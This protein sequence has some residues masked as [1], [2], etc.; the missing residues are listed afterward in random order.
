M[1]PPDRVIPVGDDPLI[2]SPQTL[3]A[4]DELDVVTAWVRVLDGLGHRCLTVQADR[5]APALIEAEAVNLV[6]ADFHRAPV[7]RGWDLVRSART[8]APRRG[9]F[10]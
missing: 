2:V 7:R 3:V 10:S 8:K 1:T 6:V 9:P 4:G 5:D